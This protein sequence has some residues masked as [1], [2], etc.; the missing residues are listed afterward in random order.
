MSVWGG[1][2]SVKMIPCS[3]KTRM[4]LTNVAAK[5]ACIGMICTIDVKVRSMRGKL[6]K[7]KWATSGP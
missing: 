6:F 7:V 1:H 5:K 2:F 4:A 3:V